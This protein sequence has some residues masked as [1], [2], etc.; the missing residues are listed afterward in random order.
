MGVGQTV[1]KKVTSLM[2]LKLTYLSCQFKC[3]KLYHPLSKYNK[4]IACSIPLYPSFINNMP[5][6]KLKAIKIPVVKKPVDELPSIFNFC[7]NCRLYNVELS[8]CTRCYSTYYCN[9]NCQKQHWEEHKKTCVKSELPKSEVCICG[10]GQTRSRDFNDV[11]KRVDTMIQES[12]VEMNNFS[13]QKYYETGV[14]GAVC[15]TERSL[16]MS[17]FFGSLNFIY[18]TKDLV[19]ALNVEDKHLN[20]VKRLID[21]YC[22]FTEIIVIVHFESQHVFQYAQ[23][24]MPN[25][26]SYAEATE[27]LSQLFQTAL[28]EGKEISFMTVDFEKGEDNLVIGELKGE[29]TKR[30]KKKKKKK[31]MEPVNV[32][33]NDELIDALYNIQ[34]D[35]NEQ[36]QRETDVWE[37][38]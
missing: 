31:P 7:S 34:Y 25:A 37:V 18:M 15:I 17:T 24:R 38:E 22:V 30:K 3:V 36:Q 9:P 12:A 19:E 32:E 35:T 26:L 14:K 11:M 20:D 21:T 1:T 13:R 10:C 16:I 4:F 8:R 6:P 23:M 33:I 29:E 2:Q 5:R 28:K 27:S